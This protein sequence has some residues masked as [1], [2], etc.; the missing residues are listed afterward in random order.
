M[1][2]PPAPQAENGEANEDDG[3]LDADVEAEKGVVRDE[4]K[5]IVCVLSKMSDFKAEKCALQKV[6]ARK[7]GFRARTWRFVAQPT[8]P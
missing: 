2:T 1:L 3:E 4:T 8:R 5:S 6:R 7:R